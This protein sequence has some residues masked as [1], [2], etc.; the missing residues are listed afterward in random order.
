MKSRYCRQRK[1]KMRYKE[2][3]GKRKGDREVGGDKGK[4]KQHRKLNGRNFFLGEKKKQRSFL[5]NREQ[6]I[7]VWKAV[8]KTAFIY[9]KKIEKKEE[10]KKEN[11]QKNRKKEKGGLRE[12]AAVWGS[13]AADEIEGG[14]ELKEVVQTYEQIYDI[15]T[16]AAKNIEKHISEK[17]KRNC[18]IRKGK[19][20][21]WKENSTSDSLKQLK[22]DNYTLKK[23]E[24]K[25][26][27]QRK[28]VEKRQK[29]K[30]TERKYYTE[31][32]QENT[33]KESKEGDRKKDRESSSGKSKSYDEYKERRIAN[34]FKRNEKG[35]DRKKEPFS[36]DQYRYE[37]NKNRENFFIDK[38]E[39]VENRK[40]FFTDKHKGRRRAIS[41]EKNGKNRVERNFVTSRYRDKYRKDFVKKSEERLRG[42]NRSKRRRETGKKNI[43][44]DNKATTRRKRYEP[45]VSSSRWKGDG[46][47]KKIWEEK[48]Q[49]VHGKTPEKWLEN[50]VISKRKNNR[51][52]KRNEKTIERQKSEKKEERLSRKESDRSRQEGR[53]KKRDKSR[54]TDRKNF[55]LEERQNQT[56]V[57]K[58]MITHY[59]HMLQ[60]DNQEK[61]SVVI[62]DIVVAKV[63]IAIA[64]TI[65]TVMT[66]IIGKVILLFLVSLPFFFLY[67][68]L[69]ASPFAVFFPIGNL[70]TGQVT[71]GEL[72]FQ[73]QKEFQ[74][75]LKEIEAESSVDGT[76]IAS[77]TLQ[78]ANLEGDGIPDTYYDILTVYAVKHNMGDFTLVLK[79]ENT[80]NLQEIFDTMCFY[81]I[82]D[83]ESSYE[84]EEGESYYEIDRTIT[85]T[86]LSY[87]DLIRTGYFN[88][89]EEEILCELMKPENRKLM[90]QASGE[91]HGSSLTESDRIEINKNLIPGEKGS[92]AVQVAMTKVGAIYSQAKRYEEGYY[93]C[94]S[95]T[96]RVYLEVGV[97]LSYQGTNVASYQ[98][99]KMVAEGRVVAYEDLAPGDLIFWANEP[100]DSYLSITHVGLYAGNGKTIEASY[101]K[102]QVVY[103]NIWGVDEIVLCARPYD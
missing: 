23:K 39:R 9:H 40:N 27:R 37:G 3:N 95:L 19:K 2:K 101:S 24:S 46:E 32:L 1:N 91:S 92:E 85:V 41:S 57:K 97:D 6:K 60:N 71:A 38:E 51:T 84:D 21:A 64:A 34:Q 77:V 102:G 54:K 18:G 94:S 75:D 4:Q 82:D 67:Q 89:E 55:R 72:I 44:S 74:A 62:K 61:M 68:L 25:E 59:I 28:E 10:L 53:R 30:R 80:E 49:C 81:T 98:A 103:R 87:M 36:A 13:I 100:C 33:G 50:D 11:Q 66:W 88:K 12:Q 42:R 47:R 20:Y 65:K 29:G 15:T 17:R 93:D 96:Y 86:L 52:E 31:D 83:V 78:Y 35:S 48:I 45:K 14:Q 79:E 5:L 63:N 90:Q 70:E 8:R 22:G 73:M 69:L 76:S 16:D 99:R 7:K 56:V 43:L 58:R 26:K